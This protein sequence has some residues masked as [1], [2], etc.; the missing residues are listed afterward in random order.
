MQ[1]DSA[2]R[3]PVTR[4]GYSLVSEQSANLLFL[5]CKKVAFEKQRK[6]HMSNGYLGRES[7]EDELWRCFDNFMV[8]E[9]KY[10]G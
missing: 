2:I 5:E 4:T 8:N 3:Y 1:G 9:K 10:F 6:R 7:F